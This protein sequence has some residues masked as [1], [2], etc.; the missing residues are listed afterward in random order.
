MGNNSSRRQ[1][2]RWANNFGR[3]GSRGDGHAYT[4]P[5]T[6]Q[7]E[8]TG[9]KAEEAQKNNGNFQGQD[10]KITHGNTNRAE[11]LDVYYGGQG[12][13]DGAMALR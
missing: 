12:R 8:I 10:A 5:E 4:S 7:R 1:A 6:R 3:G 9:A 13:P 2:E 11:R